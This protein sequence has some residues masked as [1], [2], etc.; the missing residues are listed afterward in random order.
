[1]FCHLGL[2]EDFTSCHPAVKILP[3]APAQ[4]AGDKMLAHNQI[5]KKSHLGEDF[6]SCHPGEDF[7][8]CLAQNGG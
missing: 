8:C 5:I 2:G 6:T 7:T 4:N 1:M 3:S